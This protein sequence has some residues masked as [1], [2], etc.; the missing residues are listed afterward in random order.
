MAENANNA[1]KGKRLSEA[2]AKAK[3]YIDEHRVE[4]TISEMLNSLVHAR[5]PKPTIFMVKS[6]V[7]NLLFLDQVLS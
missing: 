3:S 1:M 7:F 4:K 6:M 2:Q 5:D